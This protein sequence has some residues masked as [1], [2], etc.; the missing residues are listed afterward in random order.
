MQDSKQ[1][2]SRPPCNAPDTPA[3]EN[4][5][6]S[7]VQNDHRTSNRKT[8]NEIST[9][10]VI[11]FGGIPDPTSGDRRFSQ[12]IQEKPDA[13]D[14]LM[15]RAMRA[16]KLRDVESTTGV[17]FRATFWICTWSLLSHADNRELMVTG[18]NRWEMAAR[19]IFNRFGWR[20]SN[21]LGV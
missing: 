10:D 12:R 13:D 16:A 17:I 14:M 15:G 7:A 19:V 6:Q 1:E 18:C 11:S 5:L 9:D 21:R 20:A 2:A 4:K 8:H 3:A